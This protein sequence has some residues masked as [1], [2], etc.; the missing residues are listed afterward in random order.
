MRNAISESDFGD[1]LE[2]ESF[3]SAPSALCIVFRLCWLTLQPRIWP[4]RR[5]AWRARA[6]S[7]RRAACLGGSARHGRRNQR[8]VARAADVAVKS[9]TPGSNGNARLAGECGTPG[10]R[11]LARR[12]GGVAAAHGAAWRARALSRRACHQETSLG[13]SRRAAGLGGSARH[14]RCTWRTCA[15]SRWVARRVRRTWCARA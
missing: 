8:L 10:S 9:S 6:W 11:W 14:R 2:V 3:H 1:V 12:G 13:G 7:R 5:G 4:R 15:R